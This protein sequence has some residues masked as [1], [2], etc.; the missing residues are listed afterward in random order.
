[1]VGLENEIEYTATHHLLS[2]GEM[3]SGTAAALARIALYALDIDL[4]SKGF[5]F[6]HR[7]IF[8]MTENPVGGSKKM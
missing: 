2:L 3:S 7:L 5:H 4:Q 6:Q 8:S 1:M